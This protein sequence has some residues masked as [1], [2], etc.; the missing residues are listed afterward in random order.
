M[1]H[2]RRTI[3]IN[4]VIIVSKEN[5]R[6]NISSEMLLVKRKGAAV[7]DVGLCGV[8]PRLPI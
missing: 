2:L 7:N 6:E 8:H 5:A 3:C 1:E 4:Q